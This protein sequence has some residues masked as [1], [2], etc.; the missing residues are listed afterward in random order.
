MR[1]LLGKTPLHTAAEV[2]NVDGIRQLLDCGANI[3]ARDNAGRTPLIL[4]TINGHF[5]AIQLLVERGANVNARKQPNQVQFYRNEGM[6]SSFMGSL[7]ALMSLFYFLSTF[8]Q[9][10]G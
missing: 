8:L 4:A 3:E 2:G 1:Y 7:L 5:A 6:E 10:K 9:T